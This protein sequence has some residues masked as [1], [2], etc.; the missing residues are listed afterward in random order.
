MAFAIV[1]RKDSVYRHS[2][3]P[4]SIKNLL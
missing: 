3:P 1:S 4:H 2:D